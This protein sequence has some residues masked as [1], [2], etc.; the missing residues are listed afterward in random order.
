MIYDWHSKC[1]DNGDLS[2][3]SSGTSLQCQ[4]SLFADV[5]LAGK[6]SPRKGVSGK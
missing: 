6:A 5:M 1:K 2:D 4:E 3:L